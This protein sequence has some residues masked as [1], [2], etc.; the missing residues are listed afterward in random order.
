MV[1]IEILKLS[2][3]MG[4]QS[5]T[6]FQAFTKRKRSNSCNVRI[7]DFSIRKKQKQGNYKNSG[8]LQKTAGNFKLT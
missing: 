6:S 1:K 5:T 7:F 8:E 2:K 3:S 4:N